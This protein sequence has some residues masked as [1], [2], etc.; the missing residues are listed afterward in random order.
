MRGRTTPR[1]E[2]SGETILHRTRKMNGIGA[3]GLD[4]GVVVWMLLIN[5][6]W[7]SMYMRMF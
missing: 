3:E 5:A 7:D 1:L 2:S 6:L 4:G